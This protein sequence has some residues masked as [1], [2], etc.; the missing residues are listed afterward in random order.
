MKRILIYIISFLFCH[1][2]ISQN[3]IDLLNKGNSFYKDGQFKDAEIYYKKA[4]DKDP[5]YYK[6]NLNLG[7]SLFKQSIELIGDSVGIEKLGEA[8]KFYS[9]SLRLTKN[10][11]EKA[12]SYYN[13]GNSQL[14]NQKLEK[15]IESYKSSLRLSPNNMSTKHNLALAQSLL[16]Q[17][18]SNK[19]NKEEKDEKDEEKESESEKDQDK[20]EKKEND[21]EEKLTQEQIEE[22]LQALER[23]EEEVQ[24]ELQE[25]KALNQDNLL[26]DW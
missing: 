5:A 14:L 19:E 4:L 2:S 17:Q 18:Q 13:L 10:K 15:S 7:H 22:I 12:E 3:K 23:K 11:E 6:A 16:N 20:G 26:K 24:E 8:E 25:K 9:N 21:T 1:T